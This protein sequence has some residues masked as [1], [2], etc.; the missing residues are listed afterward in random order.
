MMTVN[1]Y[2]LY[3]LIMS[4]IFESL[5]LLLNKSL[6]TLVFFFPFV[7]CKYSFLSNNKSVSLFTDYDQLL[8]SNCSFFEYDV[9]RCGPT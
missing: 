5:I 4:G 7:K 8:F 2:I 6:R 1:I 9:I 3:I